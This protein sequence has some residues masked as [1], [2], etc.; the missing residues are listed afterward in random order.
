MRGEDRNLLSSILTKH[1]SMRMHARRVSNSAVLTV[2]RF[3]REVHIRGAVVY[4]IGRNEVKIAKSDGVDLRPEE[5][6][7]VVCSR[8]GAILTVYR[9]RTLSNLRPR[10]RGRNF[11]RVPPPKAELEPPYEACFYSAA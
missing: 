1:A 8:E 11:R 4:A 7:H 10:H 3:G 6:L 5:G 9:D 2:L